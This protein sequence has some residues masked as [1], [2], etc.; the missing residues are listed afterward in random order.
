MLHFCLLAL[1]DLMTFFCLHKLLILDTLHLLRCC[2]IYRQ[3]L[4]EQQRLFVSVDDHLSRDFSQWAA[5]MF[6]GHSCLSFIDAGGLIV[7]RLKV[8]HV[9]LYCWQRPCLAAGIGFVK[10]NFCYP[11]LWGLVWASCVVNL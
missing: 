3:N 2:V 6:Q 4:E 1:L 9:S 11:P 8:W 5:A 7:C 10:P